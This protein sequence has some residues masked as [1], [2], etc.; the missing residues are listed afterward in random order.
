MVIDHPLSTLFHPIPVSLAL[1]IWSKESIGQRSEGRRRKRSVFLR[2]LLQFG[3]S[4]LSLV[5]WPSLTAAALTGSGYHVPLL[6]LSFN[7]IE[8]LFKKN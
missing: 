1:W 2:C 5:G 7:K 6:S 3:S 8:I 4:Y